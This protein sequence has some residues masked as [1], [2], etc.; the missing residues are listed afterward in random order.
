MQAILCFQGEERY[1]LWHINSSTYVRNLVLEVEDRVGRVPE[2]WQGNKSVTRPPG[3]WN[4]GVNNAM[5]LS[6]ILN[7]AV[8]VPERRE[9]TMM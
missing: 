7:T 4:M 8:T 2:E 6:S 3:R 1:V 9:G 5:D